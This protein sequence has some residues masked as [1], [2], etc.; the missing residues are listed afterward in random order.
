MRGSE[1]A[2][3]A[4]FVAISEHGSFGK[5]AAML[6]VS[7]S[8]LSKAIRSLEERLGVRLFNRTTRSVV[9]TEAGQHLLADVKP[10][11]D[12]LSMAVESISA[13]RDMPAGMLR[14]SVSSL[15]AAMV[16]SPILGR[17]AATHPSIR[18]DI[19]VKD[20]PFDIVGGHFD[21]GIRR[22]RR[23]ER[24]M[25]TLR[26]SRPSRILTVASAEYLAK[27][28]PPKTPRD[29]RAHTCLRFRLADGTVAKWEF[30]RAGKKRVVR[31]DGS[32]IVDNVDLLLRGA[33][34]GIGIA[35][36]IEPYVQPLVRAGRL[37]P[38]LEEWSPRFSGWYIYYPSRR[39]MRAP[40]KTFIE[41]VRYAT[42]RS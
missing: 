10:A 37:I 23:I 42:P 19:S 4:A 14:L 41:F 31:V 2:E 9:L 25:V 38:V 16:I 11:L 15:A 28:P 32:L 29:L 26:I 40:L 8:A 18:V 20:G 13:F 5:A 35:Y 22:D 36:L 34:E 24:D 33:L 27:H 17:F 6:D 12:K 3:L 30:E 1:F 39:Q 21:A 7:T